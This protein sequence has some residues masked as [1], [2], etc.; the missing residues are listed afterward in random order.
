MKRI[1]YDRIIG[2]YSI[3]VRRLM[4]NT[5]IQKSR[6]NPSHLA[7]TNGI[8][9]ELLGV[10]IIQSKTHLMVYNNYLV[11]SVSIDT[12]TKCKSMI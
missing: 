12:K 4:E 2:Y 9:S 5:N 10:M 6:K 7:Q 8:S 11:Y 3:I 1:F